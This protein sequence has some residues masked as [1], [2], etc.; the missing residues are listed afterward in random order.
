M[1]KDRKINVLVISATPIK[2]IDATGITMHNMFNGLPVNVIGQIYDSDIEPDKLICSSFKRISGDDVFLVPKAKRLLKL[3]FSL[4]S[5]RGGSR[6]EL[7]IYKPKNSS[8]SPTVFQAVSDLFPYRLS[9]GMTD[10]IGLLKPDVIYSPLGGVRYINLVLAVSN[11]FGIPVIPHFMDDWPRYLYS[12]GF[13]FFIPRFFLKNR[14]SYLME[15]VTIGF[16]IS[17]DMSVEFERLYKKNFLPLMN[18][19]EFRERV[20]SA[21]RDVVTFAYV[22]GLHLNRWSSLYSIVECLQYLFDA[23]YRVEINIFSPVRDIDQ[24]K[25]YF[26]KFSVVRKFESLEP[27][28]VVDRLPE[29]D[30]LVHVESFSKL[31][32]EYTRLSI[33]TKIPQYMMSGRPI[34]AYGPDSV[35]SIS[36]IASQ[37]SGVV[38]TSE[39][40]FL[41]LF[42][43]VLKLYQSYATRESIGKSAHLAALANHTADSERKKFYEVIKESL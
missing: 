41:D 43:A 10:W 29:F 28:D 37:S 21:Q 18:C 20:P 39:G 13:S 19:V 15:S 32:S 4:F 11:K 26:S 12:G 6:P 27:D 16:T 34:F 36:Y 5:R 30:V 35:S 40:D 8:L 24:Y 22:G 25:D 14:L 7:K 31:D 3:I 2:K 17:R 1:V 42:S 23:G 33:S 9:K 38:V